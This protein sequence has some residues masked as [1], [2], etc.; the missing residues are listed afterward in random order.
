MKRAGI[1]ILAAAALIACGIFTGMVWTGHT[2][3]RS[4][5]TAGPEQTK[6][7]CVGNS[8]TYGY[9]IPGWPVRNYPYVLSELLGDGY[10]VANFGLSSHCV[11]NSADKPYR[12]TD[13]FDQSIAYNGDI[14]I[15]MMGANDAK[16]EN[17]QGID[18]FALEYQSLVEGYLQSGNDP[19]IWLCTP[20]FPH[21][22][23]DGTVSFGI[24]QDAMEEIAAMIRS[25][26]AERGYPLL[27][28]YALTAD[29]PEWFQADGVHPNAAGAAAIAQYIADNLIF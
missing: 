7:A 24:R 3:I 16:P 25:L 27:D 29:H 1:W 11:Q 19:M 20:V 15:L 28:M 4:N 21:P 14:I 10:H 12:N 13:V 9:G 17:W 23:A 5:G 26:A 18:A 8:T 2:D 22:L 6:I